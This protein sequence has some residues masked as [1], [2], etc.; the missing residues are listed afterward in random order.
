[1]PMAPAWPARSRLQRVL[2]ISQARAEAM[3]PPQDA[4]LISITS[5]GEPA[6]RLQPG[7]SRIL[8]VEFDDIDPLSF[9]DDYA[10]MQPISAELGLCIA[11]FVCDVGPSHRRIVVHC[12]YGVS[13]SAAVAKAIAAPARLRF[14]PWYDEHN[15]RVYRTVLG[16]F[17]ALVRDA[18]F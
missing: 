17:E 10:G 16:G 4:A 11:R 5:P 14:P 18:D 12:R 13:R 6:A 9:P 2:F 1:M 7:W 3:R 15:Q 8:R